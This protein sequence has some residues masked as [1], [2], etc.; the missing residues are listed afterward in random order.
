MTTAFADQAVM[1]PVP[2]RYI[3]DVVRLLEELATEEIHQVNAPVEVR[4]YAAASDWSEIDLRELLPLLSPHNKV[5]LAVLDMAAK[6]PEMLISYPEACSRAGIDTS[7][8][9]AGI[10]A[11]TKVCKRL[12]KK[13]WPVSY[14]WAAGGENYSYY[15]MTKNTAELWVKVRGIVS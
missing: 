5:A 15:R 4:N 8:G 10:G 14:E 13:N 9:R 11:L 1:Y 12:G 7:R 3:S 6:N 2:A